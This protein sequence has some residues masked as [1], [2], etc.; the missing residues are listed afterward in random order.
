MLLMLNRY[1]AFLEKQLKNT[2]E[3]KKSYR[4]N[5]KNE[6]EYLK[7]NSGNQ[8]EPETSPEGEQAKSP[9]SLKKDQ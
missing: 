6:L 7:S 8:D 9:F 1:V 2:N 3:L 5:I 4:I